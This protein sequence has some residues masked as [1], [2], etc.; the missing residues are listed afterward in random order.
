MDL[1]RIAKMREAKSAAGEVGTISKIYQ[2]CT[3]GRPSATS[4]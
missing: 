2:I 4:L 1:A 3:L